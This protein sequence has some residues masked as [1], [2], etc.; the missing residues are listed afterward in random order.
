MD[1]T[2]NLPSNASG[3]IFPGNTLTSYRVMF[4]KYTDVDVPHTCALTSLTMPTRWNNI[5][6]GE[7][8]LVQVEKEAPIPSDLFVPIKKDDTRTTRSAPLR[9]GRKISKLRRLIETASRCQPVASMFKGVP[10]RTPA[11]SLPEV[12]HQTSPTVPDVIP[13][14]LPKKSKGVGAE[15]VENRE[16]EEEEEEEEE[17]DMD[18]DSEDDDETV[19]YS[20]KDDGTGTS[21]S[22]NPLPTALTPIKKIAKKLF[23][24]DGLI[25][26]S[27]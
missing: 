11:V 20:M 4:E 9:R 26:V 18:V 16:E 5:K 7:L 10:T 25:P 22:K 2:L 14:K 15:A 19:M 12:S 3:G 27:Y 6:R 24:G 17:A 13:R 8:F 1:L 21:T 23:K